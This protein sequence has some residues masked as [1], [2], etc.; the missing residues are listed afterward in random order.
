MFDGLN[1]EIFGGVNM[2][3]NSF[4]GYDQLSMSG[5]PDPSTTTT[6]GK[7]EPLESESYVPGVFD[8]LDVQ[9]FGRFL[10]PYMSQPNGDQQAT[11]QKNA[12]Q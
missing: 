2:P 9:L 5:E 12:K 6:K 10:P 1:P 11:M 3:D 7:N 4:K 8:Q